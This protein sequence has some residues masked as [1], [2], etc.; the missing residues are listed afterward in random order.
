V[1]HT[2]ASALWLVTKCEC[3]FNNGGWNL[4]VVLKFVLMLVSNFTYA[5][6]CILTPKN[7]WLNFTNRT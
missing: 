2:T 4:K 6:C 3:N 7:I 1:P 5:T